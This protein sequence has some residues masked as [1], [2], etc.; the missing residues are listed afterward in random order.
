MDTLADL[1]RAGADAYDLAP[2]TAINERQ[3]ET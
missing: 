3:V 1:E 2:L